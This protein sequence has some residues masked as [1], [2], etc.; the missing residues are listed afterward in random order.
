MGLS[1]KG[2]HVEMAIDLLCNMFLHEND[3]TQSLK[4]LVRYKSPDSRVETVGFGHIS[5]VQKPHRNPQPH[6]N[7]QSIFFFFLTAPEVSTRRKAF[8]SSPWQHC[9]FVCLMH[10]GCFLKP[11]NKKRWREK[12]NGPIWVSAWPVPPRAARCSSGLPPRSL[13]LVQLLSSNRLLTPISWQRRDV[14]TH[15]RPIRREPEKSLLTP[16]VHARWRPGASTN[17]SVDDC[18]K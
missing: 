6:L 4:P 1:Q 11:L 5:S 15:N 18:E 16:T 7:S 13:S 17:H 10:S 2:A 14:N 3:W 8:A 12:K 9:R